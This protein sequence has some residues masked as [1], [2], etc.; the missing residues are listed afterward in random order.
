MLI[1]ICGMRD[2]RAIDA[3]VEAGADALGF[4]FAESPRRVSAKDARRASQQVPS[5][6]LRVAVMLH[7]ANDE[8]LEVRDV[9]EPDVLQTDAADFDYLDVTHNVAR[10][11]VVREGDPTLALPPQ[12]VYEGRRSGRGKTVDWAFAASL[13]SQGRMILAG[14]L[15]ES[16]VGDAIRRVRPFGVD[17]SSAVESTPGNKDPEKIRAFIRAVRAAEKG[18]A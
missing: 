18:T 9:F 5:D 12:F 13:A 6:V 4:V 8:W 11:P 2:E 10:W 7:P 1:K 3:A 16:N 15:D 17:T 14:G